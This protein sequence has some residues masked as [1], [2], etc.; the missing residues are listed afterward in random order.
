MQISEIQY[1]LFAPLPEIK[2]LILILISDPSVMSVR[3][4]NDVL[5]KV[6]IILLLLYDFI[7]MNTFLGNGNKKIEVQRN[8]MRTLGT[9]FGIQNG[10]VY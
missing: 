1:F 9:P 3:H 5:S 6:D 4:V 10:E 7:F 2:W 8:H